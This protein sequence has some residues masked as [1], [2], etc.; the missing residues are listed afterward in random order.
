ML[1]KWMWLNGEFIP[2]YTINEKEI[3]IPEKN[4]LIQFEKVTTLE[5]EKKLTSLANNFVKFIP[6]INKLIPTRFLLADENKWLSKVSIYSHKKLIDKGQS[7]HER[8]DLNS[9]E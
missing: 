6:G 1:K 4:I 3:S 2:V 9:N 7:I 8:V 5:S